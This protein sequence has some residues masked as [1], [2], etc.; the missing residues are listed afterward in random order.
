M[1]FNW[2]TLNGNFNCNRAYM[3]DIVFSEIFSIDIL[4]YSMD[5][6]E[7][8]YLLQKDGTHFSSNRIEIAPWGSNINCKTTVIRSKTLFS[9]RGSKHNLDRLAKK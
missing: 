9:S 8:I 4:T 1:S 5:S 3:Y 7:Y 2:V 6:I